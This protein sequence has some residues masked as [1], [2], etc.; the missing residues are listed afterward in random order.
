MT[1]WLSIWFLNWFTL[2]IWCSKFSYW[3]CSLVRTMTNYGIEV[4]MKLLQGKEMMNSKRFPQG[5]HVRFQNSHSWKSP[6]IHSSVCTTHK[7]LQWDYLHFY[8]V[9]VYHGDICQCLQL[10]F[11]PVEGCVHAG[12]NSLCWSANRKWSGQTWGRHNRWHHKIQ[13]RGSGQ[14]SR[15]PENKERKSNQI[16]KIWVERGWCLSVEDGCLEFFRF[17]CCWSCN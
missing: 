11:L 6:T 9:L 4:M 3:I 2:A 10:L 14:L 15:I 16:C 13:S 7:S 12:Q 8:L 17:D 5:H 1:W